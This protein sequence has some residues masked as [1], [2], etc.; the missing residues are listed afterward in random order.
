M[1]KYEAAFGYVGSVEVEA[2][3]E[4]EAKRLA[5]EKLLG[6]SKGE[7]WNFLIDFEIVE[8]DKLEDE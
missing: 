7:L 4:S 3:D 1:P 5:N 2:A 6:C 8:V